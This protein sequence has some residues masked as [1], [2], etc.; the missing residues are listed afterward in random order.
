V[1]HRK[2]KND[3]QEEWTDSI[4]K[5]N[6]SGDAALHEK[7]YKYRKILLRIIRKRKFYF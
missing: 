1:S 7:F 5:D 4:T 2:K 3:L 6:P